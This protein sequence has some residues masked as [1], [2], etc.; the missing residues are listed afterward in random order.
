MTTITTNL[1]T[2]DPL[3]IRI[4]RHLASL[5]PAAD[6]QLLAALTADINELEQDA[7]YLSYE[8]DE[9]RARAGHLLLD[10]VGAD[11]TAYTNDGLL[12]DVE[13]LTERLARQGSER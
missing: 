12:A 4:R 3:T 7:A 5:A 10:M 11:T 2:L 8:R 6:P 1:A 13:R 9:A